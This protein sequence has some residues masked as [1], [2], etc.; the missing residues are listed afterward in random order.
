LLAAAAASLAL[1]SGAQA[2]TI[3]SQDF[4]SGLSANEQMGGR[5][6]VA[7]GVG[8]HVAGNYGNNEYS[9]YDIALDLT[10]VLDAA[11]QFDYTLFSEVRW[12]GFNVLASKDGAVDWRNNLLTPTI[13]GAY[14]TMSN[15][16]PQLG[17]YAITGFQGGTVNFDLT[18]LA[19]Q[20]VTLRVQ[21]QSDYAN[22]S[23]GLTM[24]N[25]L[26]SGTYAPGFE[27]HPGGVPEPAAWAMM[28]LGFFGVG[29]LVRR[30]RQAFA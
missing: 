16:M 25:V 15:L 7:G 17:R 13:G 21:F 24:D 30:Q 6:G 29:S 1:A 8:G 10:H 14:L 9:Y 19:G 28:I 23:R 2:A 3:F 5:F 26:V 27:P 4:S 20:A 18:P 11:F 12:D 22:W